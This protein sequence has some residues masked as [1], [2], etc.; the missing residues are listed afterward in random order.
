MVWEELRIERDEVSSEHS[1]RS[2]N[3]EYER[4]GS[5]SQAA[6]NVVSIITGAMGKRLQ[7]RRPSLQRACYNTRNTSPLHE[8]LRERSYERSIKR[9]SLIVTVTAARVVRECRSSLL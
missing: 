9:A 5:V 3:D 8:P 2:L 4:H 6:D 1:E 7:T